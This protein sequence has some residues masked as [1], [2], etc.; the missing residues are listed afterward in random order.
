[1]WNVSAFGILQLKRLNKRTP[2]QANKAKCMPHFKPNWVWKPHPKEQQL[3]VWS[4]EMNTHPPP[5]PESFSAVLLSV[6]D[7]FVQ[8]NL[9]EYQL[10]LW[11]SLQTLYY[12]ANKENKVP[13]QE[14][15]KKSHTPPNLCTKARATALWNELVKPPANFSPSW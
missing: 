4:F 6:S 7:L 10:L 12:L 2:F 14:Q 8:K 1:M 13:F 3:S 15:S 9:V 11:R 5:L